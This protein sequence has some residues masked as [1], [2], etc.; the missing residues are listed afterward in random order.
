[1]SR[2]K[3]SHWGSIGR[4]D[5]TGKF[6]LA[7]LAGI[8]FLLFIGNSVS[9]YQQEQNLDRMLNS[10]KQE[11]D[12]MLK[13]QAKTARR[14]ESE[15]LNRLAALV[16][17]IAISAI[18]NMDLSTLE[19]YAKVVTEDPN[20]L[21]LQF[22][23]KDGKVLAKY[24]DISADKDIKK[25]V[26]KMATEGVQL[27]IMEMGYQFVELNQQL[28]A[29]Q[30][31]HVSK[32]KQMEIIKQ[33]SLSD[34][35][36]FSFVSTAVIVLVLAGFVAMLFRIMIVRRLIKLDNNL[37]DV[38]S[39]DG[40]LTKRIQVTSN[41]LIDRIGGHYN[42]FVEK[43]HRTITE[44][45]S[46]TAQIS[47]SSNKMQ[48]ATDESRT[49]IMQ[50]S[51][52]IDLAATAINEM[53]AT[54]NEV[55]KNAATAAESA[56]NADSE[57]RLGM[58]IVNNTI[59]SIGDLAKEVDSAS[60][61]IN[62]LEKDSESIG[63]ILDVIRGIAEQTNLLALNAAIEAARAGEQGRGFSVVADEVRTLAN[64]TQ[65]S[66]E[67]IHSKIAKLQAGTQNAVK[68]MN[69]GKSRAQLSV[70]MAAKAGSSLKSITQAVATITE[71]NTQ[72]ASAAEEQSSVSEEINRN[73]VSVRDYSQKSSET[74]EQ[75]AESS[76]MLT[77]LASNL[78]ILVDKFK[79]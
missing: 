79:V 43:L 51:T 68:V 20:I 32:I 22:K 12:D 71:M 26:Y 70:D 10:S 8:A 59:S 2:K 39:G 45:V 11:V 64:R 23:N 75:S 77:Q 17:K 37:E 60:E 49:D 74:V 52:E 58:D 46:A 65:E 19:E 73:I 54:V 48:K 13:D 29:V 40:D 18:A 28:A 1:M 42:E 36:I 27:G 56:Q 4:L 55:A 72:I 31:K 69:E 25:V 38:A 67:E 6:I 34:A 50:Q 3:K 5:I 78:G 21:Y 30:L 41:D 9:V 57:S 35:K 14:R 66:T 62:K 7:I 15:K 61:V 76:K 53:A 44:V 16:K 47:A 24:G 33:R 63:A